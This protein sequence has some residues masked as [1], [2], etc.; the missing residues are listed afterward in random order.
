MKIFK[1]TL[2]L[3]SFLNCFSQ[4]GMRRNATIQIQSMFKGEKQ[5]FKK[6]D[7]SI[8]FNRIY[9]ESEKGMV[10]V[11]ISTIGDE[12]DNYDNFIYKNDTMRVKLVLPEYYRLWNIK[13]KKFNFIKGNY[14]IDLLKFIEN[15]DNIE[16]GNLIINNFPEDCLLYRKEEKE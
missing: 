2:L 9:L 13:I 11:G 12:K 6:G 14:T 1:V 7:G 10:Y 3:M 4:P 16:Y 8:Q 15:T 5:L